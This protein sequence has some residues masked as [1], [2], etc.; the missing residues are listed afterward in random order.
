MGIYRHYILWTHTRGGS[1]PGAESQ[2]NQVLF[3][4]RQQMCRGVIS[5]QSRLESAGRLFLTFHCGVW[6]LLLY[7]PLAARSPP[8]MTK[9]SKL[10]V[11]LIKT[12]VQTQ[13][14][15]PEVITNKTILVDIV[16]GRMHISHE[17]KEH[18]ITMGVPL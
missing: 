5:K 1:A 14:A 18:T 15:I 12:G 3:V 10:L 17:A 2:T 11:S 4:Q 6:P 8:L 13:V 16:H 7:A 9:Y